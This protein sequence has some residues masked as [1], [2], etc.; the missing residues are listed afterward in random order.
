MIATLITGD[1]P[2]TV[3]PR[4]ESCA[5]VSAS[6]AMPLDASMS[7]VSSAPSFPNPNAWLGATAAHGL[8]GDDATDTYRFVHT[9]KRI[10]PGRL[11]V[12]T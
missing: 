1:H 11:G 6:C 8:G 3:V 2:S 9:T 4:P 7:S 10:R 5:P 12:L